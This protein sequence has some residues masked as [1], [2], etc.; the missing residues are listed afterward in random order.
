MLKD[1]KM[2]MDGID[3][4]EQHRVEKEIAE[5]EKK[6]YSENNILP[7]EWKKIIYIVS[8]AYIVWT[9]LTAALILK[10]SGALR[11]SFEIITIILD[12]SGMILIAQADKKRQKIGTIIFSIFLCLLIISAMINF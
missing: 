3:V 10:S 5:Q 4:E 7:K 11:I 1:M 8:I 6:Q 12:I 9:A 2:E